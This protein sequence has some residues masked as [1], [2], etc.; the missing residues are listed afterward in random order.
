MH[1]EKEIITIC[2]LLDLFR[3]SCDKLKKNDPKELYYVF[4]TE[5]IS[6]TKNCNH[7]NLEMP[8]NCKMCNG[9]V[10]FFDV[11][12]EERDIKKVSCPKCNE[13]SNISELFLERRQNTRICI[14]LSTHVETIMYKTNLCEK[15]IPNIFHY[16]REL[17]KIILKKII[18]IHRY[19]TIFDENIFLGFCSD[20]H[21]VFADNITDILIR[22]IIK[23]SDC[24]H[25]RKISKDIYLLS[26]EAKINPQLFISPI[27][28][29][30]EKIE[31]E[32]K[33]L[34]NGDYQNHYNNVIKFGSELQKL[35]N[36]CQFNKMVVHS[37]QYPKDILYKKMDDLLFELLRE[38]D[39]MKL[40]YYNC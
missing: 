27:T 6:G 28:N 12:K 4:A 2:K 14:N 16:I 38:M 24:H 25:D 32:G 19:K 13:E 33:L 20:F 18:F 31:K 10:G 36:M 23:P 3:S 26:H 21:I 35:Y 9:Y 17:K 8:W 37:Q 40:F 22:A 15:C 30:N 29:Y 39:F 7:D 1:S 34:T 5:G 11:Y